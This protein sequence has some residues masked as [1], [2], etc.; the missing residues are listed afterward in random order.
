[1]FLVLRK[2]NIILFICV[3]LLVWGGTA[4]WLNRAEEPDEAIAAFASPTSGAVIV[5]DAGHG[6][7]HNAYEKIYALKN[8]DTGNRIMRMNSDMV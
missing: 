8:Q 4:L 7:L 1:M 5:I 2:N 6:A 3:T